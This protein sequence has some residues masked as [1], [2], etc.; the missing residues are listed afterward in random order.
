MRLPISKI[1]P[2][3]FAIFLALGWL[4]T[5]D[6][7]TWQDSVDY[8]KLLNE[9]GAGLEDGTGIPLSMVE[10][11]EIN[12]NPN[13]IVSYLPDPNGFGLTTKNFTDGSGVNNP[14][15]DYSGHAS[16]VARWFFGDM[17]IAQG[18]T[19]MTVYENNDYIDQQLGRVTNNDPVDQSAFKVQNHSWAGSYGATAPQIA[20]AEDALARL[21][22]TINRDGL[23]VAVGLA[24]STAAL[25][26]LMGQGYNAITVGR[27]DGG[28]SQGLTTIYGAGRVKPDIVTDT[29]TTSEGTAR[30]S[31]V[32]A[33]LHQQ[34]VNEGN[35]DASRPEMMK[36]ILMAG[37]TKHEFPTWDRTTTRPLDDIF[38]A[39]ELNIYNSYKIIEAGETDGSLSVPAG[40]TIDFRGYDYGETIDSGSPLYYNLE[41][42]PDGLEDV[43]FNLT[44]NIDVTDGNVDINIFDPVTSLANMSLE[45]FDINDLV[46]PIDQSLSTVDNVEHL[47]F[48]TLGAGLYT[49]KV[50]TDMTTEFG[51]AWYA[52][53]EPGSLVFLGFGSV[54]VALGRRRRA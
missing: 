11:D 50:S 45:I 40:A 32:L 35:A 14:A 2:F 10:A 44:W 12:D 52:V 29:T 47:Y 25:P 5:A 51:L 21:D 49:I 20:A 9:V 48:S 41:V 13:V 16:I 39:G 26:Q 6:A 33:V 30:V 17:S 46:N 24:N 53:P 34:A 31:S 37:A 19:D 18:E 36:S 4:P 43:T 15:N 42:G 22:Y 28:S 3:V 27:S 7:Q 54:A 8:T 1:S 23:S 38:G